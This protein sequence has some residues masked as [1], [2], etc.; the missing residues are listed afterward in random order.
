MSICPWPV[1]LQLCSIL[2]TTSSLRP[3][4]LWGE[5]GQYCCVIIVEMLMAWQCIL[6]VSVTLLRNNFR[7]EF[8]QRGKEQPLFWDLHSMTRLW[9]CVFFW[10]SLVLPHWCCLL[11]SR[12]NS[13]HLNHKPVR[14]AMPGEVKRDSV[15]CIFWFRFSFILGRVSPHTDYKQQQITK[16]FQWEITV[17]PVFWIQHLASPL[18]MKHSVFS[19]LKTALA[20][21]CM[22][23]WM[24]NAHIQM[25]MI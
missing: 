24:C 16:D 20:K 7:E 10:S 18:E 25:F 5:K 2:P 6:S 12:S 23:K 11:A 21:D 19:L 14:F 17:Y 13:F 3:F 8:H 9:G 4:I 22:R 1:Q 15:I